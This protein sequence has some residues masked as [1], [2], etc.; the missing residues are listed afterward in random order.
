MRVPFFLAGCLAVFCSDSVAAQNLLLNHHFDFD[1]AGWNDNAGTG[2]FNAAN[3]ANGNPASGSV[4]GALDFTG[5]AIGANVAMQTVAVVGGAS[6]FYGARILIPSGPN[7]TESAGM[8]I[9]WYSDAACTVPTA[10]VPDQTTRVTTAGTWLPASGTSIS[11]AGS[12]CALVVLIFFS[13][14]EAAGTVNFDEV[15]FQPGAGPPPPPNLLLNHHFDFDLAGWNDNGGIG[16]FDGGNDANGNPDSGSLLGTADLTGPAVGALAGIQLVS[17][18]G[19]ATYA[20]GARVLIPAGQNATESARLLVSWYS[21]AACTVVAAPVPDESV[22]V[23]TT[24]SWALTSGT[25]TAPANAVCS[26]VVLL[27]SGAQEGVATV[28]FDDLFFQSLA[29][30]TVAI[31]ALDTL[32]LALLAVLLAAFGVSLLTRRSA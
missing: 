29:P 10:L 16:T 14:Q 32:R 1:L 26:I 17:V 5:P 13:D 31:P 18:V 24:G 9:S 27:F 20:F 11:P 22:P 23:T 6:Y 7:V 28:N 21:D 19:G 15:V 8:W 3:D 12:V 4:R 30:A 25:A 2:T